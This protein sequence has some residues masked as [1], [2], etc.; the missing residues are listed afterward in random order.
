MK[1]MLITG[2][3]GFIGINAAKYF[4]DTGWHLILL[5]NFFRLKVKENIKWLN[6]KCHGKFEIIKSDITKDKNQLSFLAEKVDAVLHLAAQVAVTT[7]VVDPFNDLKVNILGTFNVLE[8]VRKST[9][10]PML[11]Y[12]S[13]NKV[14]GTLEN[15]NIIE[16]DKKY[17][18][19]GMDGIS[20]NINLDFHSPYGCSKG[21]ADQYVRDYARIYNLKTVVLRQSCIYGEHQYGVED[22]GWIAWFIIAALLNKKITIYGNGKQVRDILFI[23]DLVKAYDLILQNIE[24]TRGKVYNIGGGKNNTL[25]LLEFLER[26]EKLVNRKIEYRFSDIRQ[27]DQPLFIS[28]NT[29]LKNEIGWQPIIN[30]DQGIERIFNWAKNN[31]EILK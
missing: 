11:I 16:R 24:K 21:A 15:L 19:E 17:E 30:I 10:Q 20:E 22:Q 13:T 7:S 31:I 2:G 6:Q 8:A 27:G 1:S 18:L 4:I 9:G 3:A 23:D 26:L 28:D 25:S 29:K 14:Y 5:D 12:S